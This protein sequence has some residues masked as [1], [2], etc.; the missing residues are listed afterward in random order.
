MAL[1]GHGAGGAFAVRHPGHLTGVGVPELKW[2]FDLFDRLGRKVHEPRISFKCHSDKVLEMMLPSG[3]PL[4]YWSPRVETQHKTWEGIKD[5]R[6]VKR[7][8]DQDVIFYHAKDPK[9]KQWV[10]TDTFGGHLVENADQGE[11]RD[12]LVD[13]LKEADRIGFQVVGHTYDEAVCLVPVDSHLGVPELCACL[14]KQHERYGGEL[15]LAAEGFE[16]PAYRKK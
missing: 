5:G 11:A 14:S 15:P 1:E 2:E 7:E 4:F 3:R 6:K 13:G 12:I 8:Y 16:S 10:E 9:T